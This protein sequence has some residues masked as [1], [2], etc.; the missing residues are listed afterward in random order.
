MSD[1]DMYCMYIVVDIMMIY[2][3]I[4]LID[5]ED[6]KMKLYWDE[7]M[8]FEFFGL[9]LFYM[10]ISTNTRASAARDTWNNKT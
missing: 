5:W 4:W 3:K 9:W 6:I 7:K 2:I 10:K 8:F 1:I